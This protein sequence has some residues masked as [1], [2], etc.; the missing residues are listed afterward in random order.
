MPSSTTTTALSILTAPEAMSHV[1]R[2]N[3]DVHYENAKARQID[4]VV[5]KHTPAED[6]MITS[7]VGLLAGIEMKGA[8]Q[9]Q[10]FTSTFSTTKYIKGYFNSKEGTFM[11]R[12]SSR[13]EAAAVA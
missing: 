6:E 3:E 2:Y 4:T 5:Q 11:P 1:E 9:F 12:P 13:L 7:A 8:I 10:A